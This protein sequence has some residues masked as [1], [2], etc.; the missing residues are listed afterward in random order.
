MAAYGSLRR[1]ERRCCARDRAYD[2]GV[3]VLEK[4]VEIKI[5]QQ[6]PGSPPAL[7]GGCRVQQILLKPRQLSAAE[8]TLLVKEGLN[9]WVG[10]PALREIEESIVRIWV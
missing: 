8:G 3:L 4:V 1:W 5:Q 9:L 2:L 7:Q 6:L 10:F